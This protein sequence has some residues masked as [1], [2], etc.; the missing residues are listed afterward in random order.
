VRELTGASYFRLRGKKSQNKER[1]RGGIERQGGTLGIFKG[2]LEGIKKEQIFCHGSLSEGKNRAPGQQGTSNSSPTTRKG[3]Y[4]SQPRAGGFAH[5]DEGGDLTEKVAQ[6]CF[7]ESVGGGRGKMLVPSFYRASAQKK[8]HQARQGGKRK[9]EKRDFL[10]WDTREADQNDHTKFL[11][12]RGI[13]PAKKGIDRELIVP[14]AG[15]RALSS[16][17]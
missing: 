1:N 3:E 11:V 16:D 9:E 5:R 4:R 6:S 8:A 7:R 15:R 12:V 10:G 17:N 14:R 2:L 13:S